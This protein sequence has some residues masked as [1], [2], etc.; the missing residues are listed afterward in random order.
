MTCEDSPGEVMQWGQDPAL[1]GAGIYPPAACCP[2]QGNT[3]LQGRAGRPRGREHL[4]GDS[5]F[6]LGREEQR[7]S[8]LGSSDMQ[9]RPQRVNTTSEHTAAACAPHLLL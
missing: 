1:L 8:L 7:M 6:P 3:S 9:R 5:G 2:P 4:P